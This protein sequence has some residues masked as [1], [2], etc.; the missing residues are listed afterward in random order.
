MTTHLKDGPFSGTLVSI[1]KLETHKPGCPQLLEMPPMWSVSGSSL[2]EGAG[3]WV[4]GPPLGDI[5]FC[6]V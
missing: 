1:L 2:R 4:R 6:L 3:L 5:A